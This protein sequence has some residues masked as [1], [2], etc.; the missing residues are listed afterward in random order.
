MQ[1]ITIIA[2]G[3]VQKGFLSDG[4]NEYIKRL[5]PMCNFKLIE[6]DDEHL[7]EKNLNQTLIDKALEKE[8]V[9]ILAHIP[10]QSYVITLCIEGK[11]LS[12]EQLAETIA[13][14]GVEGFSNICFIIGSSHGLCDKVKKACDMRL[15]L[16]KMTFPHRLARVMLSEALYRSLSINAGRKYH[17]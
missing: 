1:N 4:C 12:S 14:K 3:K 11:Q 17:K 5:K 13:Q 6:L 16:S 15:S 7:P 10:K 8:S 2:M 9:K